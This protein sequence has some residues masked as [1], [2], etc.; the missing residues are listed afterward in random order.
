MFLRW[1]SGASRGPA[2]TGGHLIE[3]RRYRRRPS[4]AHA[5]AAKARLALVSGLVSALFFSSPAGAWP[6]DVSRAER[7][8]AGREG[9]VSFALIGPN[10]GFFG[11]RAS[12][13]VPA[14]SVMK[15]MFMTAYLRSVRGR[16][17][18]DDDRALLR[19]MITRSANEPATT[20]AN[21]L[22]PGPINRL[23][24]DARMRR[25]TY[26]RPW[27]SSSVTARDQVRFMYGLDSFIPDRHER[28]ARRL[29]SHVVESQRWGI[30]ELRKP[31]WRFFFKGG[32]GTGSGAVEHQ[33]AFLERGDLR[34][35]VAVMITG[36]PSHGY[37][38]D[39]LRGVFRRLLEDLPKPR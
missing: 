2:G 22:G 9:S 36:S 29:L 1:F 38:T 32:W 16:A 3:H 7:Y 24:R 14:A 12:T 26:R 23:A 37:A 33:V 13:V 17:L 25:F 28:Y 8:A 20:I 11:S 5:V 31:N 21:R 10:G 4:L 34:I 30:G 35:A 19:P 18:T 6:P 15:V 27:G 39:T